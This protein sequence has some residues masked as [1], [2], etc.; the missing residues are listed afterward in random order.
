MENERTGNIKITE[1]RKNLREQRVPREQG[2]INI[3]EKRER[4]ANVRS[5]GALRNRIAA[6]IAFTYCIFIAFPGDGVCNL[7]FPFLHFS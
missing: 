2:N 4:R 7:L 6:C 3:T 1:K 5:T